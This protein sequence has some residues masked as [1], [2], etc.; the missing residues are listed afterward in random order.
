MWKF[1]VILSILTLSSCNNNKEYK[2]EEQRIVEETLVD[3]NK[4]ETYV[5]V[6]LGG[7]SKRYHNNKNCRGLRRCSVV[8]STCSI[9]EAESM[10]RTPC[11]ICY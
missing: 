7:M 2:S 5:W 4:D 6:C 8:P 10:G 9:S 1:I 11:K 3:E